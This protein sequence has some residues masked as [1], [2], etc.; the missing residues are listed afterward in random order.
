MGPLTVC[1]CA[2]PLNPF[3][4]WLIHSGAKLVRNSGQAA[5]GWLGIKTH[6]GRD[7]TLTPLHG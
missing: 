2:H 4:P 3:N 7:Y 1:G 6:G 5:Y